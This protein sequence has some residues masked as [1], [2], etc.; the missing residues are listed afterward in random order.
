VADGCSKWVVVGARHCKGHAEEAKIERKKSLLLDIAVEKQ[1]VEHQ[2][3]PSSYAN[4]AAA[5][6]RRVGPTVPMAATAGTC[7][8]GAYEAYASTAAVAAAFLAPENGGVGDVNLALMA[9]G[10]LTTE[11][12]AELENIAR[13]MKR[14][15]DLVMNDPRRGYDYAMGLHCLMPADVAGWRVVSTTDSEAT[16]EARADDTAQESISRHLFTLSIAVNAAL[17]ITAVRVVSTTDSEATIEARADDTAQESTSRQL[18][19]LGIAV[20]AAL[21]IAAVTN[22]VDQASEV[23]MANAQSL[24][25]SLEQALGALKINRGNADAELRCS[26]G[27]AELKEHI[28]ALPNDVRRAHERK[29]GILADEFASECSAAGMPF[30]DRAENAL[31]KN[32]FE[33]A[34]AERVQAWSHFSRVERCDGRYRAEQL[35]KGIEQEKAKQEQTQARDAALKQKQE[36]ERQEEERV[37]A[38]LREQ[39]HAAATYEQAGGCLE[40]LKKATANKA[41][42]STWTVEDKQQFRERWKAEL[43]GKPCD[44]CKGHGG[45]D[46]G[47]QGR[48]MRECSVCKGTGKFA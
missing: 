9:A 42:S 34:E 26:G 19:A 28:A 33:L 44:E 17:P 35:K 5:H 21:P 37:A 1:Q 15:I 7:A 6:A 14:V 20:N 40:R 11:A 30:L 10:A 4:R 31:D 3:D 12:S 41:T 39:C 25:D 38:E 8:G 45:I 36:E 43:Q 22:S 29:L 2:D 32:N 16:I 13:E 24:I 46:P 18:F 27:I 47:G 48:A 23:T